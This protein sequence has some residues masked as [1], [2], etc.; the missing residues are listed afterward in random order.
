[1]KS[2]VSQVLS[3]SAVTVLFAVHT[4]AQIQLSGNRYE[5]SFDTLAAGLPEGWTVRTNATASGLGTEAG[6]TT[7]ATSWG[8]SSGQFANYASTLSNYGTNFCGTNESTTVQ[9]ACTNRCL[10]MRQTGSFGDPGAAFVLQLENTLGHAGFQLAL[11]IN[12]LSVQGRTNCWIVDYGLGADPTNFV[13]VGTNGDAAVFGAVR[14]TFDFGAALNNQDQPVWIRLVSLTPSTGSGSRDTVGIDN[15]ALTF[16]PSGVVAPI[17]LALQ[18]SGNN[19][20]LSWSNPAFVL[21]ASPNAAGP[22]TN[23]PGAS[24]PHT[25]AMDSDQL[26]FRLKAN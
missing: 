21:Q 2:I 18:K 7:N 15:V 3:A 4:S 20:V 26:Y 16:G 25:R 5:Q 1:M 22:F 14:R 24:S 10:A 8:S 13:P 23:V 9:A 12:L 19:A 6:F 11:D 17:P